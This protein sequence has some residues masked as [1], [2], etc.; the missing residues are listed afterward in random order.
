MEEA[1]V[2]CPAKVNLYLRI[3]AREDTGYHQIE[4]LFQRV[5]LEDTVSVSRAASG[6]SLQCVDGE[7]QA[8][9]VGA[10]RDNTAVRAARAFL[11]RAG[12]DGGVAIRLTKRIP[13]GTGLGGA[14]SDAAGTLEAMNRLYGLPLDTEELMALGGSVGADVPFF[15]SG[16]ALAWAWGRGD[17]LLPIAP[18]P[19]AT[20]VLA[21][22][23]ERIATIEAYQALSG[24]LDLPRGPGRLPGPGAMTWDDVERL[25]FND[26]EAMA[27]PGHPG[28]AEILESLRREGA[29]VA[30]MTGS[31]S[32]LFGVFPDAEA[33]ERA[34][35]VLA[36]TPGVQVLVTHTSV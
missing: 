3:L 1:T 5:G 22:P 6:V 19:E 36:E 30:R 11:D 24:A 25:Q 17:R 20:V 35:E 21:V 18:L 2:A 26:F 23:E 13:S 15:T 29:R 33:G 4:T 8:T 34:A 31:G 16:A 12:L 32:A 9:D 7:G 27:F 10:D 14:S 28:F